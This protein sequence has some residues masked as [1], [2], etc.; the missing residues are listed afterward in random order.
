MDIG[1]SII[2]WVLIIWLLTIFVKSIYEIIDKEPP[3]GLFIGLFFILLGLYWFFSLRSSINL[4]PWLGSFYIGGLAGIILISGGIRIL[5]K[6]H[7]RSWISASV[8]LIL[9]IT[10]FLF[11]PSKKGNNNFFDFIENFSTNFHWDNGNW[12]P[13]STFTP[14]NITEF[15]YFGNMENNNVSLKFSNIKLSKSNIRISSQEIK[16][17]FSIK[18]VDNVKLNGFSDYDIETEINTDI[19]V[20]LNKNLMISILKQISEISL[21]K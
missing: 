6:P 8:I 15:Q 1:I 16:N 20:I 12:L 10:L 21:V 5:L 3:S 18:G 4:K 2:Q 9:V 19:E 7:L 11:G 13:D 14:K 17:I